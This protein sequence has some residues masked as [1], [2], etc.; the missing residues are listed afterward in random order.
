M[1]EKAAEA[2]EHT[3]QTYPELLGGIVAGQ[4]G[5]LRRMRAQ[6]RSHLSCFVFAFSGRA[7]NGASA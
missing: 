2:S 5:L 4:D 7:A 1:D 6:Q 3:A